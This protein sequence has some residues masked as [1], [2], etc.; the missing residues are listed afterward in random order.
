M[1]VHD[2]C[3]DCC[4]GH[5]RAA[6]AIPLAPRTE[7]TADELHHSGAGGGQPAQLAGGQFEVWGRQLRRTEYQQT[8]CLQQCGI[9]TRATPFIEGGAAGSRLPRTTH[10]VRI[11]HRRNYPQ[12]P[13]LTIQAGLRR[14]PEAALPSIGCPPKPA[15]GLRAG[16]LRPGQGNLKAEGTLLLFVGRWLFGFCTA[17]PAEICVRE[18][19]CQPAL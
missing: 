17:H 10:E 16:P 1:T 19:Q 12:P 18:H 14:V 8:V 4:A 3:F 7:D 9:P 11:A 6:A 13:P 2:S 5:S 15:G